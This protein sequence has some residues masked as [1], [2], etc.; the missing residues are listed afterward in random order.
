MNTRDLALLERAFAEAERAGWLATAPNPRVG[1]LALR[2]GHVVGFGHHAAWGGAHAEE[3]ALRDAGAWDTEARSWRTGAVDELVVSLEPC[4]SRGGIKKRQ[5]CAEALLACG[6]QRLV[7]GAT[8]PDPRHRGA[9]LAALRTAG[10]EIVEAGA[11]ARFA[12][13]NPAFLAMLAHADRPWVL[14]KWAASTDGKLAA[15]DGSS[16]WITGPEARAEVHRLRAASDAV[17]VGAAT[18]LHDDPRLD[19]RTGDPDGRQPLRVFLLPTAPPEALAP[20]ALEVDGP[21]LWVLGPRE[22]PPA[23]IAAAGDPLLRVPR[24]GTGLELPRLLAELHAD[25]GVRRL[26]VEGGARLHG[27][28]LDAGCLD[29]LV[30]YEAPLLLGGPRAAFPGT[31]FAS[32]QHGARLVAEERADLGP[33]LRRAFLVAGAAESVA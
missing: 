19:A 26:F 27:A 1:A 33:D 8:D 15:T 21:R 13:M 7:V 16:Q 10:V 14:A 12:A 25:H 24:A 28:L 32:P 29:A 30:R 9:G 17:L 5:P 3:A 31:G 11:D 22:E 2:A 4:S 23:A 20:R 18:L 6:V